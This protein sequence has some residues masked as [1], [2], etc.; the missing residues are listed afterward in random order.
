MKVKVCGLRK[1]ENIK[2][3]A[4]LPIDFIGLIFYPKSARYIG[5]QLELREWLAEQGE[6]FGEVKRVGVFVNAEVDYIL[7]QVHDYELDYVQ[8]HGNESPEYCRELQLLWNVSSVRKA[9][10]VKA[11]SVDEDF[12]FS[13][14]QAFA[15]FC[16]YFLFDTKGPNYG[17]NG[18]P[19]NWDLLRAYQGAIPFFLSGGIDENMADDIRQLNLPQMA[20]VDINSRFEIEPGVKDVEKVRKFV[21]ELNA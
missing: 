9:R 12:D 4:A 14:T 8:L 7:N 21:S 10:L 19:F 11:F 16:S 20:G 3:I 15:S 6:L 2:E 5:N 18:M 13:S 1:S 17:G